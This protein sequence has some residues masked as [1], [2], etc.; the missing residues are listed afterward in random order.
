MNEMRKPPKTSRKELLI[1]QLLPN[2][3]TLGAICLGLTAIRS[4]A[5][6]SVSFAAALIVLAGI[7][8]GLDGR[9]ARALGSESLLGAEL[10]SLADF[11]NFGVAP[12]IIIY[13]WALQS[14][15]DIGWAA[16]L[17]YALCCVMRL[18]RFNVGIKSEAGNDPRFFEGVPSPAGALLALGPLFLS[19]AIPGLAPLPPVA[20][21]VYLALVGGLMICRL[22]TFAVKSAKIYADHAPYVLLGAVG[23]LTALAVLPW[24]TL[25]LFDVAYLI[26]LVFAFRASRK[27]LA[28]PEV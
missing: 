8:D 12:A 6:G 22:P 7:L 9:L 24:I 4:A 27:P 11:L 14:A 26:S 13:F 21:A 2:A 18:A 17:V 15:P 16:V 10:D 3:I 23:V 20:V 5:F 19:N 1:I 25:A 28:K